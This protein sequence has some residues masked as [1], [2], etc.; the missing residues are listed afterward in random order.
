MIRSDESAS[1]S[2]SFRGKLVDEKLAVWKKGSIICGHDPSEWRMDRYGGL[3]R[4]A[5]Y[6]QTSVFGWATEAIDPNGSEELPNLEP[7]YWRNN[8]RKVIKFFP[9]LRPHKM[10]G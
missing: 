4:F 9:L 1:D 5:E 10:N 7:L 6:G 2:P 3:I 8:R